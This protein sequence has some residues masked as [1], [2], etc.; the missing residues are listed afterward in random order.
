MATHSMAKMIREGMDIY[1]A[2][3]LLAGCLGHQSL[4]STEGYVRLCC[5]EYPDLLEKCSDLNN[6]VYGK[7]DF[8]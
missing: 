8:I 3:P 6:F 5:G 7:E 2:L 4:S 1:M